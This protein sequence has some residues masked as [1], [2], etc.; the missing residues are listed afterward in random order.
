[1]F[2]TYSFQKVSKLRAINE[3]L[4]DGEKQEVEV[5]MYC[6]SNC[7]MM[8]K[9]SVDLVTEYV[10]ASYILQVIES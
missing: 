9:F 5:N 6:A 10:I 3:E 1:M 7:E 2:P 4:Q 8:R